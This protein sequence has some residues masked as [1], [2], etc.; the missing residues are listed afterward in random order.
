MFDLLPQIY[1][2]AYK[3]FQFYFG[4]PT[5]IETCQNFFLEAKDELTDS[6]SQIIFHS[7]NFSI[8]E[9]IA[10]QYFP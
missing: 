9:L 5:Y 6:S 7:K 2:I 10:T 1:H 4:Y 8:I 3:S